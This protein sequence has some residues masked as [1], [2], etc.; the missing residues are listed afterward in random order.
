MAAIECYKSFVQVP[1]EGLVVEKRLSISEARKRFSRLVAGVSRGGST[2]T[3]TQHGRGRAA[4]IGIQEYQELS[5]KA[6][7][8]ERY[9]H[10]TKSFSLR[11][12][13]ELRCSAEEL[14]KEM[15][16]VRSMWTES[17]HGSSTEL[18]REMPRK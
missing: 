16:R 4:L 8:F 1:G 3:I 5:R 15:R 2:V 18:A 7:A 14:L 13:L 11:G 9:S 17:I 6:R 12:S 10:K